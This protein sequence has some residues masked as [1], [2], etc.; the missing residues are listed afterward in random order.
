MM[1]D[2]EIPKIESK[3]KFFPYIC[4]NLCSDFCVIMDAI[5][6]ICN[7]TTTNEIS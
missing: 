3:N 5:V 6:V 4:N 2:A 1:H 7:D